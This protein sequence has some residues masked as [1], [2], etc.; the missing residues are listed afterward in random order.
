MKVTV[1]FNDK[2]TF[3]MPG[4]NPQNVNLPHTWNGVDGQDGGNDYKRLTC[5]Y[6][7]TFSKP[8]LN[9]GDSCFVVFDGVNS[10]AEVVLNGKTLCRHEGGY[11]RFCVDLTE[12]LLDEN[13][14]L[15]KVSNEDNANVYP[16]RADFTFY[17]GIY[18]DVTLQVFSQDSFVFGECCSPSLKV[19]SEVCGEDGFLNVSANVRGSGEVKISVLDADGR[20]V[21]S[22]ESNEKIIVKN[23]HLWDGV[24]DPY[25]YTVVAEL[26]A[27]GQKADET[28]ESIG[29]R[30]F[31][32]SPQK[33]FFLNGKSY[34]LRGVS[35]HQ[36]RPL[37]G[38]ALSKAEHEE[39]ISLIREI[40]ANTIRLAHYQHADYFYTLCDKFGLVVWAEIPYISRHEPCANDNSQSQ[41]RELILQNFNHPSICFWGLSNEITMMRTDK[42]DMVQNHIRLNNLCHEADP[43]R[44]TTLAC[45]TLCGMG[46]K[47][48]HITD[49]VSWNHYYGWYAPFKWLYKLFFG[50]FRFFFPK[51]AVGLSE[52]GAE[53]MPNLHSLHPKRGDNTEEYQAKY[54]EYMAAFIEKRPYLWGTHVWNMFDFAADG[55]NQGGEPGRNHKGLVT[56]DRKTKKDS[57]FVYKAYWSDEPFVHICG[58]RFVNRTG[59]KLKIKVYSN[60][61]EV[62]LFCNGCEV[63]RKHGD[64]VF[65]FTLPMQQKNFVEAKA[66]N[67]EHSGG[68]AEA[69]CDSATFMKVTTKDPDYIEK[70][71]G[72]SHSWEK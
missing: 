31:S 14:L 27:N 26:F 2:W 36:D 52:Y 33:G 71:L 50:A 38:N 18:R 57:F 13:T 37:K 55:R 65:E 24:R 23:V 5:T 48:A 32:V 66:V 40:G 28:R 54:H 9:D 39:D 17:G 1:P 21:A 42:R 16:R 70:N 4:E 34:P 49:V 10:V 44:L 41:M 30:Y 60:C 51:R 58:K 6:Q 56:F 61:D 46:N 19:L 3:Q 62:A 63:A 72:S 45:F 64:K 35:R 47:I 20:V 68:S 53:A 8:K 29:F 25:L 59:K 12:N 67:T 69:P 15:V 7:K 22:G 43:T 11:S